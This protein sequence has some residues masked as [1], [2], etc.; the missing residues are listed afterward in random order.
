MQELIESI[1]ARL[2]TYGFKSD[3]AIPLLGSIFIVLTLVVVILCQKHDEKKEDDVDS[4]VPSVDTSASAS[5]ASAVESEATS[6]VRAGGELADPV[7]RELYQTWQ[8]VN[9]ELN[10]QTLWKDVSNESTFPQVSVKENKRSDNLFAITIPSECSLADVVSCFWNDRNGFNRQINKYQPLET[11][12]GDSKP[13]RA[14]YML[15][16]KIGP[17][18]PRDV[19]LREAIF[20]LGNNK[21]VHVAKSWYN[22]SKDP[23][24]GTPVR[25]K[26]DFSCHIFEQVAGDPSKCIV[27]KYEKAELSIPWFVPNSALRS[28]LLRRPAKDFKYLQKFVNSGKFQSGREINAFNIANSGSP[29]DAIEE[30]KTMAPNDEIQAGDHHTGDLEEEEDSQTNFYIAVGITVALTLAYYIRR[31]R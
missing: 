9:R 17:L 10:N 22:C 13:A 20:D 25:V 2:D 19:L 30:S 26:V 4:Y 12:G 8:K 28:G 29:E 1:L 14:V 7:V 16:H 6:Q 15:Y 18:S 3:M 23:S 11:Y 27:T 31:R 21:M 24:D 5:A